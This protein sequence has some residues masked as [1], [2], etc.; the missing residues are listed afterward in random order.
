MSKGV[1]VCYLQC[2]YSV[3][4]SHTAVRP[5]GSKKK[6]ADYKIKARVEKLVKLGIESHLVLAAA[7]F[8]INTVT[9][10]PTA[11][12]NKGPHRYMCTSIKSFSVNVSWLK[13][14]PSACK[15]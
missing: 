3:L 5:P 9:T 10:G 14:P 8:L 11:L 7:A 1:F 2:T 4:V 13:S 6:N 15:I 12:T